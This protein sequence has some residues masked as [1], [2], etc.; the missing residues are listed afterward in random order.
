MGIESRE[1][2]TPRGTK[3]KFQE[4]NKNNKNSTPTVTEI[5]HA[6][7]GS[8]EDSRKNQRT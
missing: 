3:R 4:N 2:G 6:L 7:I 8:S 5:K 1:R